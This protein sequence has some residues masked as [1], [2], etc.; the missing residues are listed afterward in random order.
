MNDDARRL[1]A[2]QAVRD[3]KAE[4]ATALAAMKRESKRQRVAEARSLAV[5]VD[6]DS[7]DAALVRVAS[8]ESCSAD[9]DLLRA[10]IERI[11]ALLAAYEA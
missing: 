9:A 5:R 1:R 10:Y 11:E 2:E 6:R 8:A 7:V 3:L 4:Q